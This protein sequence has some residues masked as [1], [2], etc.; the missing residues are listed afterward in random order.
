M[1]PNRTI[2]VSLAAAAAV[3]CIS[4]SAPA[5]NALPQAHD[6]IAQAAKKKPT[7]PCKGKQPSSKIV[8][9]FNRGPAKIPLRCGNK[10][11]GFRHIAAR[12]RWSE[13]F[14]S[15]ISNTLWKG[16]E[17]SPGVVFRDKPGVGCTPNP[18]KNFKVVYNSGP[19]GGKPGGITPQG[20]IT[21]SVQYTA[22]SA[23]GPC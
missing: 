13:S 7:E 21:A 22:K 1:H 23:K 8:Y 14:K 6:G 19:L 17:Q 20:V 3:S 10:N 12:G 11:W 15:K 4:L 2:T 16:Y 9:T 5:A 18:K